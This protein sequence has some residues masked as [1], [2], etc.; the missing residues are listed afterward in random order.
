LKYRES[1]FPLIS[2]Q[3]YNEYIKELCRHAKI[4]EPVKVVK[5]IGNKRIE[6]IKPKYEL[7][8]SH[9][10]RRTFI[11]LTLKKGILPETVMQISGHK[12]RK[13]FQKYVLISQKQAVNE[14]RDIWDKE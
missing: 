10:A 3:K 11:T 12:D 13:S 4:D 9:T 14:V 5:Q 6:E 2:E 1:G 7:I 8:T